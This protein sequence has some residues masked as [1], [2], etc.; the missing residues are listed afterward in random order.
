MGQVAGSGPPVR[1]TAAG[2]LAAYTL[3]LGF[4]TAGLVF[5]AVFAIPA[6]AY[7][8]FRANA[9]VTFWFAYVVTRPL[10]A[11][12]ADWGGKP[13]SGGGLGY[14]DGAVAGVLVV[15]MLAIIGYLVRS[16]ADEP[17]REPALL[18]DSEPASVT[19]Y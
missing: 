15:A 3:N 5:A 2:D 7:G 14:G 4:L 11:S 16:D 9:I 8:L 1:L 19:E 10:G 6:L 12:F 13:K 17:V 18:P